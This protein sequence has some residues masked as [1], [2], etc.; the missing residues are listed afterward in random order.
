MKKNSY[1]KPNGK[2]GGK[3]TLGCGGIVLVAFLWICFV[4]VIVSEVIVPANISSVFLDIALFL[5]IFLPLWIK[6]VCRLITKGLKFAWAK[7]KAKKSSN[8]LAEPIKP[9]VDSLARSATI[10]PATKIEPISYRPQ[11]QVSPIQTVVPP[12]PA[13]KPM[14]DPISTYTDVLL[15]DAAKVQSELLSIDLMEG[16]Q[17]EEW[18]A[19]ALRSSGFANVSVTPGSGDQGVDVLAE[20]DGIKYAIQC[21]RY[22][23]DLGNTPIQEVH[24]GKDLYHRHVGVVLTNQ[25]FTDGA[26]A[27][28]DA[29]GT[30][31]WDRKWIMQYLERK[32]SVEGLVP[33]QL[34]PSNSSHV[35]DPDELFN[36]AVDVVLE[37]GQASV[38]M[39][40]RR[41]KLG[42]ARAARLIDQMEEQGIVGPFRGSIPR[43]IL[44]TKT[45]W[46]SIRD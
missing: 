4:S 5:F 30:L 23:K 45:Q 2:Q 35:D 40:Q 20:K 43:D 24:S 16:H 19:E 6:P 36:A 25:F 3:G 38:S 37:T 9:T 39:I 7:I 46:Q 34:Q 21:K 27:L 22:N 17:F 11:G 1:Y 32:Y 26:K 31:L 28:A 14:S 10:S 12:I 18:C 41:L 44:I 33:P 15:D 13:P 8:P 42:Y 29:T